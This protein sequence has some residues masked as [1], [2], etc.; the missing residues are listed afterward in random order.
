M[1]MKQLLEVFDI[2]DDSAAS[3]ERMKDYLLSVNPA[4]NIEVFPL[5]GPKGSTDVI[6]VLIP[7]KNGK[8]SGRTAPTLGIIGRLGGSVV[9]IFRVDMLECCQPRHLL[10]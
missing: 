7:G 8:S 10:S 9:G 1:V 5:T 3:G 6:R 2:L 4:A